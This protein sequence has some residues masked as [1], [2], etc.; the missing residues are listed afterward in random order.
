MMGRTFEKFLID[1]LRAEFLNFDV[2]IFSK[3]ESIWVVKYAPG[4]P[5]SS[6]LDLVNEQFL[7]AVQSSSKKTA[8]EMAV[9]VAEAMVKLGSTPGNDVLMPSVVTG[10]VNIQGSEF[11]WSYRT[12]WSIPHYVHSSEEGW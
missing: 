8:D 3:E 1:F 12:I 10:S 7:I 5:T 9:L 6:A 2:E 11:E 4:A